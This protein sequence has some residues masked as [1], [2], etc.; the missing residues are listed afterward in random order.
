MNKILVKFDIMWTPQ[1]ICNAKHCS[2][3]RNSTSCCVEISSSITTPSRIQVN[4]SDMQGNRP[5]SRCGKS[6]VLCFTYHNILRKV[7]KLI[8]SAV[9][10]CFIH[11]SD[12]F[13]DIEFQGFRLQNDGLRSPPQN[14]CLQ[15]RRYGHIGCKY[16]STGRI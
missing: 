16:N 2:S 7:K 15:I 4:R 9:S 5:P 14:P 11:F 10:S 8:A 1:L 12:F 3:D 6:P 13:S